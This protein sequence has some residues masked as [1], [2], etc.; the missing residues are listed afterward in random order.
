MTTERRFKEKKESKRIYFAM[1]GVFGV[2]GVLLLLTFTTQGVEFML[3]WLWDY[4]I[5]QQLISTNNEVLKSIIAEPDKQ[6]NEIRM[7]FTYENNEMS[8]IRVDRA[9]AVYK[10]IF[11]SPENM[12]QITYEDKTTVVVFIWEPQ[13]I[14]N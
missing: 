2:L 3:G 6:I 11:D 9:I 10:E 4:D 8:D 1:I 14:I 12:Y 13:E 7:R 5:E